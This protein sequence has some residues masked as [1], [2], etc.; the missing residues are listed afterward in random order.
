MSNLAD[1]RHDVIS[2]GPNLH[3]PNPKSFP[4]PPQP[5]QSAKKVEEIKREQQKQTDE[6]KKAFL[7]KKINEYLTSDYLKPYLK[8]IVAP[9]SGAPLAQVEQCMESIKT[10]LKKH[11]KRALVD[12]LF[13][14]FISQAENIAVY[15]FHL[16]QVRGIYDLVEYDLKCCDEKSPENPPPLELRKE[17]EELTIELDASWVPGPSIR[18]GMKLFQ[19]LSFLAERNKNNLKNK[20]DS[21]I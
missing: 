11:D 16:N 14:G 15:G 9:M 2:D 10:A 6:E 7:L 12:N 3:I 17:L 13:K 19:A 18:L 8:G 5:K 21:E 4:Q 1:S 20:L